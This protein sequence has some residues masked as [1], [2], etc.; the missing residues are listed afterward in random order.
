[1]AVFKNS[2]APLREFISERWNTPFGHVSFWVYFLVA[3]VGAGAVG[4]WVECVRW[5]LPS[6][7]ESDGVLT[8]LYTYFPAIAAGSALQMLMD[9]QK[10]SEKHIRSFSIF[11]S[12]VTALLIFPHAFGLINISFAFLLGI[13]GSAFSLWLWWIANGS[14]PSFLDIDP[15]DSLGPDPKSDP[16]GNTG[17]FAT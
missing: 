15:S 2:F 6:K 4:I 5:L 1:M 3:I 13:F 14:N 7:N 12:A 17:G 10:S 8:A 9:A 16:A 11:C